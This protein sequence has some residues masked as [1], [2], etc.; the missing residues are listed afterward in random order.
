M[1]EEVEIEMVHA[2]I[3]ILALLVIF[4][5]TAVFVVLVTGNIFNA[6]APIGAAVSVLW[7]VY[8]ETKSRD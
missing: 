2:F 3:G 5:G 4:G 1:T 6:A 8:V 7:L